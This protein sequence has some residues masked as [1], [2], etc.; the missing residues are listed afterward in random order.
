MTAAI[1]EYFDA[2][3]GDGVGKLH[4]ATGW[5]PHLSPNG[6]Y[7]HDKWIPTHFDY[8]AERDRAA[9]ELLKASLAGADT[10]VCPYLM[11]GDKRHKAG[12][13]AHMVLH[14]DVDTELD[15]EKIRKIGGCAVFSGT[16]GHVHVYIQLAA[17]IPNHHHSALERALVAYLGGD[18][19]KISDNDVLRPPDTLNYKPTLNNEDPA[20]VSWLLPPNGRVNAETLAETLKV[21]LESAA[22][23][24]TPVLPVGNPEPVSLE[25]HP[26][27]LAAFGRN[28]GD[29]S[30]DTA[31][32]V[33]ACYDSHLTLSQAR[34]VVNARV[35]LA[36]RLA[37]RRDDDVGTIWLK[38]DEDRRLKAQSTAWA[39]PIPKPAEYNNGAHLLDMVHEFLGRFVNYPH[40]YGHVA[41]TLWIAHTWFMDLWESTPRIAFLSP[42]PASGKSRALEVTEAL[43]PRPIHSVNVTPAYLF[44][45]VADPTGRPTIL[46]DEIDTVFGPKAKDNEE[47]R[48]LLNSGHRRGAVAGRCVVKGKRIETEEIPSFCAVALAGLHSLPDTILT[49]S[50]VI[51]MRRRAASESIEPWRMSINGAEAAPLRDALEQWSVAG[52]AATDLNV[53][54]R[55][56]LPEGI[57]DRNADV[58]EALV[59][60]GELAGGH[61]PATARCSAVAAV[62]AFRDEEPSLGVQLLWDIHRMFCLAGRGKLPADV[63]AVSSDVVSNLKGME[64]APWAN[65]GRDRK[66]L[67]TLRLSKLLSN[68]G[69]KS[70]NTRFGTSIAKAYHVWQFEDAWLRYGTGPSGPAQGQKTATSATPLHGQILSPTEPATPAT[71]LLGSTSIHDNFWS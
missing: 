11:H 43:V 17:G 55:P 50:V 22:P 44:R 38:F 26:T 36:Q 68:Y 63:A 3:F 42:E 8:P 20:S 12:A 5:G 65:Y 59:G 45:K 27:V 23:A 67:D 21:T 19:A 39:E 41:H 15:L 37:E 60:V 28:T 48:G 62:A 34:W 31:R 13:V 32:I 1:L 66:G 69:I 47:I 61:W 6:K 29:R 2:C 57:E 18:P 33:G 30:A 53:A 64:E 71:P 7:E 14:A 70:R 54:A 35:D 46:Y 52:V 25:D 49:R 16:P 40:D 56:R 10:Y 51:R 4:I 24:P 58:W 9:S